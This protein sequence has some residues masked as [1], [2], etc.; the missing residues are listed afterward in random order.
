MSAPVLLSPGL[1]Q[2]QMEAFPERAAFSRD[3]KTM[4]FAL[5]DGRI[6]VI[7]LPGGE[8]R[9]TQMHDG[10]CL[11]LG[12]H[13]AGGWLSG[14]DDGRLMYCS[15]EGVPTEVVQA[16]GQWLEHMVSSPDG[17][18]MAVSAGREVIVLD[19]DAGS[20]A[21]F[22]PHPST[23]TGLALSPSGA[24][25]AATHAGGVSLWDMDQP[26]EPVKLALAGLSLAPSFSPDCAYLACGHQENSIHIINLETR[27]VFGLAGLP[28]KPGQLGWTHDGRHLMH[29]G[30]K[31]VICW[32]VPEC[33]QPD[34]T[35]VAF[36]VQQEAR[37]T[38]LATNPRIP[39]AA[40]GFDDGTLLLTE[41]KR[42][43][44]YPLDAEPGSPVSALAWSAQG[45]HLACGMQDGRAILLDLGE[46]LANG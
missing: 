37:M 7:D 30:T 18:M 35:P 12:A 6:A 10:S 28:A 23:V 27:T 24:V 5:G 2:W 16:Q 33:F 34:P 46:L 1:W 41:F 21:E 45:V 9:Y 17:R 14:G 36:A 32:P 8:P 26:G 19:L 13:P 31:A 43:T 11:C 4:A 22:G 25:L 29:S 39:F 42:F 40:G 44:A 20:M 15:A 3:G 38:A